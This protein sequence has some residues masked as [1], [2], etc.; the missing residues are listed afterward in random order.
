MRLRP[1]ALLLAAIGAAATLTALAPAAHAAAP[2]TAAACSAPVHG[3]Q[4]GP[5]GCIFLGCDEVACY[6]WCPGRQAT[7]TTPLGTAP[8]RG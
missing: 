5:E 7:V 2:S 6:W 8:A 1:A 4:A 3:V